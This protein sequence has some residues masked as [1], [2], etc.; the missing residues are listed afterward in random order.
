M[1]QKQGYIPH[2]DGIRT[3]AVLP[4]LLYHL[5]G[6]IMP[7]GF[8]GVDVFFV[9]S[10]YLIIGGILSRLSRENFSYIDFYHRRAK[11][12]IPAYF[13][14][15]I[16][17]LLIGILIFPYDRLVL[18]G[19]TA[20]ASALYLTNAYFPRFATGYFDASAETNPLLNLWSLSVEQQFYILIPLLLVPLSKL[21][22]K[23]VKYS[24]WAICILSFITAV[25]A[26]YGYLHLPGALDLLVNK[27]GAFYMLP[28][29]AWELMAG[30]VLALLPEVNTGNT[31]KNS[32]WGI[33]GL[34]LILLPYILYTTET[35]FPGL[36]ALPSVLGAVILI[37]YGFAGITGKILESKWATSIG[38]ISYSLYLYHWPIFVFWKYYRRELLWHDYLGMTTAAFAMALVSYMLLESPLRKARWM[39][40]KYSLWGT[41][42]ICTLTACIGVY[43]AVE[44]GFRDTLHV[45]ANAVRASE[46]VIG[47]ELQDNGILKGYPESI[48]ADP[49]FLAEPYVSHFD[50]FKK[51]SHSKLFNIG[52]NGQK[53]SFLLMGDSHAMHLYPGLNEMSK[54]TG[55]T[56]VYVRTSITPLWDTT[57][58]NIWSE[59]QHEEFFQ[60]LKEHPEIKTVIIAQ[61]WAGRIQP[62]FRTWNNQLVSD[63]Q[64]KKQAENLAITCRQL[65]ELGCH[66]VLIGPIPVFKEEAVKGAREALLRH[67][68]SY[69]LPKLSWERFSIDSQRVN[70]FLQEVHN[71]YHRGGVS[72][73][74]ISEALFK[75]GHFE[76][77]TNGKWNY[78]D[79]NHLSPEGSVRVISHVQDK[80]LP[81]L[82]GI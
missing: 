12:I 76:Y 30:G 78:K 56:G 66:V 4:V 62:K 71:S 33:L 10:G 37:R 25:F 36:A 3:L 34:V 20:F 55:L 60:W 1:N 50:T 64:L 19:E 22:I 53:P 54:Q 74:S 79:T 47:E 2:I 8:T 48:P 14:L 40:A 35:P 51:R 58:E 67:D 75:D 27:T 41:A 70:N 29:R 82:K 16:F 68:S 21:S 39:K 15:I 24:I 77:K 61:L 13:G 5:C 32:C 9:I 38:K 23:V 81:I 26:V 11:R 73:I 6:N 65:N 49:L 46:F 43:I 52:V 59:K 28:T 7:G 80:L 42:G 44:Q 17:T 45:K 57:P 18:L 72:I 31:R 69:S 63:P